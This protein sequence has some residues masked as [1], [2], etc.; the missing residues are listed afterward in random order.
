MV[1]RLGICLPRERTQVGALVQED[2]TC[3]GATKPVRPQLL[4]LSSGNHEPQLLKPP[5]PREPVLCNKRSHS[6]EEPA[7]CGILWSLLTAAGESPRS[8]EDP[9]QPKIN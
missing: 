1:Q 3:R 9:M 5:C 4:S 7:H 2:P 8:K 6:N